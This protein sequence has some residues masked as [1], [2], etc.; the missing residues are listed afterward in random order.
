M[1][2]AR[3]PAQWPD[4][5]L[6]D[7]GGGRKLERFSG[8]L[9]DRPCPAAVGVRCQELARWHE[10][11]LRFDRATRPDGGRGAGRPGDASQESGRWSGR[12]LSTDPPTWVTFQSM[13]LQIKCVPS[14]QLGIFP[15]QAS[16]WEWIAQQVARLSPVAS[17]PLKLLN[18]FAYTGGSTLAAAAQ[19]A[20]VTHVD[21]A[22]PVVQWARQN[23][24]AS[25]LADAP[26]RWIQ[27]DAVRFCQRELKRGRGYD[28]VILDPPTYGH[29]PKREVWNVERDL[30][31]LLDVCA[32][33]T[34]ERLGLLLL[35]CHSP[36]WDSV[37]LNA[38][39]KRAVKPLTGAS[40]AGDLWL[41]TPDGRQ[42]HSGHYVRYARP[43]R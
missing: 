12:E 26:I 1:S 34:Q 14:G 43:V 22:R 40:S 9:I 21:A 3:Q 28:G 30:P 16:N 2:P 7:F 39:I 37:A 27:E 23:A 24:A 29:G 6:V 25:G 11:D 19:G 4:Y 20:Q 38:L 36:G 42:L 15:E 17:E 31:A 8:H 33:L 18:L 10:A 13:R 35:T 5:Q 41:T 32:A